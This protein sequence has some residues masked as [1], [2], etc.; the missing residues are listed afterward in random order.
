MGKIT[1]E[2]VKVSNKLRIR[3]IKFT[4]DNGKDIANAYDTTYNCRFPKNIREDGL[5]Y[6]IPDTDLTLSN[7]ATPF[8][9]IKSKNIKIIPKEIYMADTIRNM[10]IFAIEECA[11][12]MSNIPTILFIPCGHSCIC[13]EC[14]KILC[15][16]LH[17]DCPLCRRKITDVIDRTNI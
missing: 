2:C 14:E 10:Q 11:I 15:K 17:Y 13:S 4:D 1:L 3:F 5:F 9:N 6:E 12:C 7:G 16:Q 8:Y